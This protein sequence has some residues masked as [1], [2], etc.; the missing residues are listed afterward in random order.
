ME[1]STPMMMIMRVGNAARGTSTAPYGD[2]DARPP[3]WS[4]GNKTGWGNC[5][6]PPDQAKK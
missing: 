6:L 2:K 5:E 3:G 1:T 4:R